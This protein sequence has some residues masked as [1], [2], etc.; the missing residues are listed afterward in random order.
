MGKGTGAINLWILDIKV[1]QILF[2]ISASS[3]EL[4]KKILKS[5]SSKLPMSVDF[6]IK[7]IKYINNE[8]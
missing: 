4:A 8:S 3:V 2:E 6:V 7:K 1:G 5:A